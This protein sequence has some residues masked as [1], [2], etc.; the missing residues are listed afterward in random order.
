ELYNQ[1]TAIRHPIALHP[2]QLV[3]TPPPGMRC[4][5]A[6]PAYLI[7]LHQGCSKRGVSFVGAV[8][9]VCMLL[10]GASSAQTLI[11]SAD[12]QKLRDLSLEQLGNVDVTSVKKDP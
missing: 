3:K 2:A 9:A 10:S 1:S 6:M 7:D 8:C 12:Q 4:A 11:A 5:R